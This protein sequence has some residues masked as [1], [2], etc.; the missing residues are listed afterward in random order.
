MKQSEFK[1]LVD[2]IN[3]KFKT[4]NS[5]I[6]VIEDKS[7]LYTCMNG[8]PIDLI[9]ILI[10][11]AQNSPIHMSILLSVGEFLRKDFSDE[12]VRGLSKIHLEKAIKNS[13]N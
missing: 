12:E 9:K 4:L 11:M 8:N 5:S 1:N 10:D 7:G 13:S 2:D 3:S 6:I